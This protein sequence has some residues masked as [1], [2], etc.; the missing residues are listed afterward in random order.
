MVSWLVT[1][2]RSPDVRLAVVGTNGID[3]PAASCLVAPG[4]TVIVISCTERVATPTVDTSQAAVPPTRPPSAASTAGTRDEYTAHRSHWARSRFML[5]TY[6]D[7]QGVS[8]RYSLIRSDTQSAKSGHQA[9]RWVSAQ[10]RCTKRRYAARRCPAAAA[11]RSSASRFAAS[12]AR[13]GVTTAG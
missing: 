13:S 3:S 4:G 1:T 9:R 2:T 8:D 5:P 7:G 12:G 6:V 11:P 10:A